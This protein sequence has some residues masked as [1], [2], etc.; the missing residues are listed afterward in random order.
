MSRISIDVADCDT[1]SG[2]TEM[3][4]AE[5]MALA[6]LCKRITFSDMRSCAVDDNEAYV[7]R[8][9]VDKLQGA[10]KGAGYAPR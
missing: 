2:F 4:A 8:D 7:I 3:S 6:Q 1:S 5:A 10:L 9:A